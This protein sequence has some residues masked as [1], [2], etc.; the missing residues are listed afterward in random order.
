VTEFLIDWLYTPSVEVE[1]SRQ[2]LKAGLKRRPASCNCKQLQI[3]ALF[4]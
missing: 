2:A 1:S 4:I 3:M